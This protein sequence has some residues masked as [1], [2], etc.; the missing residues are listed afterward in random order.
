MRNPK[1]RNA[2]T[3]T[4]A[5]YFNLIRQSLR[6]GFMYWRP[7]QEAKKANRRKNIGE[8]RHKYIYTCASCSGEFMDKEVQVDHIEP[9]GSLRSLSDIIPFIERLSAEEG[10]QIL[11]RGCH[12]DKSKAEKLSRKI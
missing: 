2:G 10:Y 6:R 9:L 11:C 7:L 12:L 5:A 4:E 1:T 3:M 8:G